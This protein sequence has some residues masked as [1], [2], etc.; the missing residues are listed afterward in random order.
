MIRLKLVIAGIL[1]VMMVSSIFA[2]DEKAG[3]PASGKSVKIV[4]S[5]SG[6]VL[7]VSDDSEEDTTP[8]CLAKDEANSAR[9][10]KI[11]K[12]GNYFK[13]T[14]GKSGKV[15][16][17]SDN[18]VDEDGPIIIWPSK[19]DEN[20]NQRWTWDGEGK[21]RRIKSKVSGLVL[22]V[23]NN[24]T[25][26]QRR[27]DP[28]SKS[29]L[30][31]VVE[32]AF[33]KLVNVDSGKVLGI[34]DDSE[35]DEAQAMVAT[36]ETTSDQKGRA[37]QWKIDVDAGALKLTNRK[38]GKVLDV[39]GFSTDEGSAIIQY[40]DKPDAE[41]NDNQRWSWDGTGAERRLKSKS[42]GMVLDVEPDGSIVQRNRNGSS[43]TQLWRIVEV[44]E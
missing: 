2:A 32:P 10:W 35:D 3:E 22:D 28:K 26:V 15:M 38:S 36:N 42:S 1:G 14:N 12:D 43:K 24:G 29:Q 7:G 40:G 17:V 31:R 21:D 8:V 19:D 39:S 37:Q 30:W 27:A 9:R 5:S 23:S 16:D 34:R 41:G 18:S 20:D 4:N 44:D 11:E 13:L 6:K 25:L 33:V